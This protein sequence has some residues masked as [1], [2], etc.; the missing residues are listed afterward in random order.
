[1]NNT[2]HNGMH[3]WLLFYGNALVLVVSIVLVALLIIVVT[4]RNKK[5][6]NLKPKPKE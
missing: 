2:T 1:M 5:K 6:N 3:I 4:R